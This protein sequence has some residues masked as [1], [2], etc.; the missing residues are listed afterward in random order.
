M[1]V[2]KSKGVEL[3]K[4][5]TQATLFESGLKYILET[6]QIIKVLSILDITCVI[7]SK[8]DMS[9]MFVINWEPFAVQAPQLWGASG[10]ST[11]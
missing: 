10:E 1:V 7:C 5:K 4:L 6:L 9:S 3:P 11:P 8:K 2:A